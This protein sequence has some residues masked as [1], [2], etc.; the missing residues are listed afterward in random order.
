MHSW[1]VTVREATEIQKEMQRRVID[2][3]LPFHIRTVAGADISFSRFSDIFHACV[4]V[5][6]Y[7]DLV[8]VARSFATKRVTFPY[9]PGYLSFRE[10]PA[11]AE[12]YSALLQKPDVLVMDGQGIAHPRRLGVAAHLGLVLDIPT[13]GVAKSKLYGVGD[14]P[15]D[16]AGSISYLIDPKTNE[17]I[18]AYLRTKRRSNPVIIS[19]GHRADLES[20][21]SLVRSCVRGYRIPEPTRRAHMLVNQYRTGEIQR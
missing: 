6:S 4:V 12:A 14:L 7:P 13:V 9:V 5:F 11:I 20:S 19:A 2:A 18:G 1:D 8:E 3:P 21:L 15:P 10:V 16:E 17:R